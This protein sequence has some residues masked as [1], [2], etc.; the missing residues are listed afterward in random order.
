MSRNLFINQMT[1]ETFSKQS[2]MTS[3]KNIW[4]KSWP[5]AFSEK[6][7]GALAVLLVF[8]VSSYSTSIVS[9]CCRPQR[10][11]LPYQRKCASETT[12]KWRTWFFQRNAAQ[13][14]V[15]AGF[16]FHRLPMLL[17]T[18]RSSKRANKRSHC[19]YKNATN[20]LFAH[21]R[22]FQ[23]CRCARNNPRCASVHQ[24]IAEARPIFL[25]LCQ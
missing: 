23:G 17:E 9:S 24:K 11:A 14:N 20:G 8:A 18:V 21:L 5:F 2:C 25:L 12:P 3:R 22:S 4:L 13:R 19:Y 1:S 15:N 6:S 7:L 16:V 10:S